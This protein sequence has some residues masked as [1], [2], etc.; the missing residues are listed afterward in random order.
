[1]QNFIYFKR[2]QEEIIINENFSFGSLVNLKK[3][4]Y[5]LESIIKYKWVSA[6]FSVLYEMLCVRIASAFGRRGEAH[7]R[8]LELTQLAQCD[9]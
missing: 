9:C 6:V 5:R 3:E 8:M 2:G 4:L 1:M 7:C